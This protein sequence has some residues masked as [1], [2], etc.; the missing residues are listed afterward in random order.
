MLL[1][2]KLSDGPRRDFWV[3]G[4][5]KGACD[6]AMMRRLGFVKC[7]KMLYVLGEHGPLLTGSDLKNRPIL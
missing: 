1:L 6:D 4:M 3:I 7:A 2:Y 5:G